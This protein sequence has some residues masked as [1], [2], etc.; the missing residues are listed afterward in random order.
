MRNKSRSSVVVVLSCIVLAAL[1]V[2][3]SGGRHGQLTP[4]LSAAPQANDARLAKAWKFQRDMWTYVHLEGTPAEIGFQHGSLLSGEIVDAF[5][6]MK[7]MDTHRTKR[8]WNFFRDTA[9]NVLW[10]HIDR[11]YQ[12][13]LQGIAD[14]LKSKGVAMDVYDVVAMNAFEEVP[15]YYIPWLEAKQ[16]KQTANPTLPKA[17]RVG[18]PDVPAHDLLTAPGNCS[19]FVATGSYT[20]DGKPVIAHNNWTSVHD[21]TRWRIMFDIV[22]V[23]GYRMIMD[24]FPGVIVSDDDFTINS[25]GLAVTE[26]T[27]TGFHGWDSNGKP[28]FMRARKATQYASSIDEYVKI[29]NEGNNGGYANDW[30]LADIKTG[31]VARFEQGLKHTRLWRTKD[32][33][34][35]GSNFASDPQVI[36]DETDFD[37]EKKGTSPNARR[38]RWH[39]LLEQNKGKIDTA[40]AQKFEGDHYDTFQKKEEADERSLCGHVETSPRGVPEWGWGP[41]HPGGTVQAK[42]ADATMIKNMTLTARAGHACGTDFTAASFL[43]KHPEYAWEKPALLDMKSGPWATFKTGEKK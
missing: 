32:G 29:M 13:E 38:E 31:E 24:G 11:E 10:P 35:E 8:D 40:M 15:D 2:F 6:A 21:G 1:V 33:Y 28:E 5:N 18:H 25:A 39:Q 43:Q 34:F 27:I 23:K 3:L 41:Y 17:V 16:K 4:K 14:G 26:T 37:P 36:K 22:P 42:A 30:L 19:A 12:Q 7:F 20:K 9:K